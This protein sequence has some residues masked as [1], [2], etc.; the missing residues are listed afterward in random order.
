MSSLKQVDASG[1]TFLCRQLLSPTVPLEQGTVIL[2]NQFHWSLWQIL[3]YST[4]YCSG[5]KFVYLTLVYMYLY[6]KELTHNIYKYLQNCLETL[7]AETAQITSTSYVQVTRPIS[8]SK[9]SLLH[10]ASRMPWGLTNPKLVALVSCLAMSN[11]NA[12]PNSFGYSV[13]WTRG[14]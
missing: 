1:Q 2:P 7:S 9:V 11:A 6:W 4:I 14:D 5:M 12:K 10:R 8:L 13:P 3:C